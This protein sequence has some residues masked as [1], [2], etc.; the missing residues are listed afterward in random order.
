MNEI[1]G[2]TIKLAAAVAALGASVGVAPKQVLAGEVGTQMK[3][4]A[5]LTSDYIKQ[6]LEISK[7]PAWSQPFDGLDQ[8]KR[9]LEATQWKWRL[10]GDP[11]D[12]DCYTCEF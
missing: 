7:K 2:K 3:E 9:S 6:S 10:G 1:K 4:R 11:G 12:E 8:Y 5:Q